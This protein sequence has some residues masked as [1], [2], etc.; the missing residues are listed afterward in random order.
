MR[1]LRR[2]PLTLAGCLL[3]A[4]L[5]AQTAA[6]NHLLLAVSQADNALAVFK[7]D[8]RAVTLLKTLPIGNGTREVCV[9][10]DGHRAYASNDKDNTITVVDLDTLAVTA[11]IPLPG[12]KRPDGCA[13]SPDSRKLYVAGM[14]SENVSVISTDTQ[15]I[16]KQLAVDN[17]PRRILFSPDAKR[18]YVSREESDEIAVFDAATEAPL[19]ALKSGGHGPRTMLFLPDQATMLATNVDDDTVSF[20]KPDTREV[21]LT[22]GS[23]GSPQRLGLSPDGQSAYVLSVLEHK[24][25]IIDLKGPHVRAKKFVTVGENPWG[26]TMNDER[27]LLFVGSAKDNSVVAYDTATMQPVA[28]VNVNRPMGLAYR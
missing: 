21:T 19:G 24:I 20:I 11:T 22:I 25:S 2:G 7:V 14:E 1:N 8:G 15:K 16:L 5:S 6:R 23:G 17:E 27:T 12:V 3:A 13:T 4:A 28:T 10:A 18:L 26:M 9:S